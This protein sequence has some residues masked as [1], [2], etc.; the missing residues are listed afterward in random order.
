MAPIT[1]Q[2][3]FPRIVVAK[4]VAAYE[5]FVGLYE[6][7]F[8]DDDLNPI[9]QDERRLSAYT[10]YKA[11]VLRNLPDRALIPSRTYHH[12]GLQP[13]L[14]TNDKQTVLY[15]HHLVGF[16]Q[17]A[18]LA[19]QPLPALINHHLPVASH[20]PVAMTVDH[21]DM[22]SLLWFHG[23]MGYL[24]MYDH[25]YLDG[26]SPDH[27]L[28]RGRD[29][30]YIIAPIIS[31]SVMDW[32]VIKKVAEGK[33][34]VCDDCLWPSPHPPPEDIIVWTNHRGNPKPRLYQMC[35]VSELTL[36]MQIHLM[37]EGRKAKEAHVSAG[38]DEKNGEGDGEVMVLRPHY[39]SREVWWEGVDWSQVLLVG[40]WPATGHEIFQTVDDASKP[41]KKWLVAPQ[42]CSSLL[43]PSSVMKEWCDLLPSLVKMEATLKL[44]RLE[45]LIGIPLNNKAILKEATTQADLERLE[46]LGD[47]YLKLVMGQFVCQVEPCLTTEGLLNSFRADLVR[48]RTIPIYL[49]LDYDRCR[50]EHIYR[51]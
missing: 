9:K 7:G 32:E 51:L 25:K 23:A 30:G 21:E 14:P 3:T 17:V 49:Y 31:S 29:K 37:V 33:S 42:F 5:A 19:R 15:L 20:Q 34:L 18:I 1:T 36:G 35:G 43:V 10:D 4:A 22:E 12:L 44:D 39:N 8:V 27:T 2:P 11:D 26:S 13:F 24:A 16:N 40:R 50:P 45:G 41:T 47:S 6:K 48:E 38:L 46:V 28:D